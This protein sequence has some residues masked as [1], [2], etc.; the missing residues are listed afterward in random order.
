MEKLPTFIYSLITL[1][2]ICLDD[3]KDLKYIKDDITNLRNLKELGCKNCDALT[4]PPY[5]VCVQGLQAVKKYFI[6]LKD[7]S[8][9]VLPTLLVAVMGNSMSGKTSLVQSLKAR[10]RKLT[11]RKADTQ[12]EEATKVFKF[13][14]MS[15]EGSP[16]RFLDFGGQEVYHMTYQLAIRETSLPCIVVNMEEFQQLAL[17]RGVSEATRRLCFDWLAHFY[18]LGPRVG[19]PLLILTHVD[20]L[21]DSFSFHKSQLLK[22]IEEMRR[23]LFTEDQEINGTDGQFSKLRHMSDLSTEVFAPGAIFSLSD[24]EDPA[25]ISEIVATIKERCNHSPVKLPGS[26]QRTR[27]YIS[28]KKE[29]YIKADEILQ[30]F[31]GNDPDIVLHHMHNEGEVLWYSHIA[32]LADYV[33]H[34]VD[35]VTAM[36]SSLFDIAES[37]KWEDRISNHKAFKYD[38]VVISKSKYS[39]LVQE[40]RNSG[41]MSAAVLDHILREKCDFSPNISI[42]L[43]KA[44]YIIHGPIEYQEMP[45]YMIPYFSTRYVGKAWEQEKRL[46]QKVDICYQGLTPPRYIYQLHTVRLLN[47]LSKSTDTVYAYKNGA[48]IHQGNSTVYLIHNYNNNVV[49]LQI[50]T[51]A[52]YVGSSWRQLLESLD[53]LHRH[54]S[55]V[56]KALYSEHIFYCTHC[57]YTGQPVPDTQIMPGWFQNY[58]KSCRKESQNT[59]P[60][61]VFVGADLVQCRNAE[62]KGQPSVPKP[63]K[64]PC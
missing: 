57:I 55:A 24:K 25:C 56:W 44:F 22:K 9:E 46:I 62:P 10:K 51:N 37:K 4:T 2:K 11:N 48:I 47:F 59:K 3:N 40:F 30:T 33:F 54:I 18:I 35:R 6:D 7:S 36:I 60:S 61:P 38:N 58:L 53:H 63:L 39:S 20:K 32:S 17:S 1:E 45:A 13:E 12:L 34:D 41:I 42:E 8:V 21:A 19:S 28:K 50:A 14:A 29:S 16:V 64:Y 23:D 5:S 15:I 27:D 52:E 31:A 49:T 43:L 26:W